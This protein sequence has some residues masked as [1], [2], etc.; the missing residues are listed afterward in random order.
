MV[1][2]TKSDPPESK[3]ILAK[4]IVSIS[5]AADKLYSSG[6]NRQAVIVL[7]HH[8]TKLPMRDIKLVLDS[9][10]RLEGWYCRK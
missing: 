1:K 4:A 3:E 9:L 7:L 10:K 6:V 8:K 2:V 5:K